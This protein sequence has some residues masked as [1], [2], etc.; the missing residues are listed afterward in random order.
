MLKTMKQEMKAVSD[1]SEAKDIQICELEKR[2]KELKVCLKDAEKSKK[3]FAD[4]KSCVSLKLIARIFMLYKLTIFQ[5]AEIKIKPITDGK[6]KLMDTK[7]KVANIR[8]KLVN[9]KPKIVEVKPKLVEVKPTSAVVKPNSTY[10]KPNSTCAESQTVSVKPI[11]TTETRNMTPKSP[12]PVTKIVSSKRLPSS[13]V[14]KAV[15]VKILPLLKVKTTTV[16]TPFVVAPVSIVAVP[17]SSSSSTVQPPSMPIS[18]TRS[19][20]ISD[21]SSAFQIPSK[22]S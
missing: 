18:G 7:L 21:K 4:R 2:I 11:P 15:P 19:F 16:E 6:Q 22:K 20:Q 13:P 8:P 9:V 5:P 17:S 10:A 12:P 14:T 3:Q 1:L